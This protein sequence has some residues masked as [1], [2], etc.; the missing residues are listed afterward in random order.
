MKTIDYNLIPKTF[1]HCCNSGCTRAADCLRQVAFRS[2]DDSRRTISV[3]N[4]RLTQGEGC[5]EYLTSEPQ[6]YKRGL[7]HLYDNMTMK[8]A[9][10]V[11]RTLYAH[12]GNTQYY[13]V[14]NGERLIPPDEQQ[15]ISRV[16]EHY[17]ITGHDIY[18]QEEY[19]LDV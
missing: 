2:V 18:D 8:T 11:R 10:G 3:L 16:L 7:T 6:S 14:V 5:E 13:R 17:G 12:Y 4:P 1:V 19:R 15:Y 9:Q